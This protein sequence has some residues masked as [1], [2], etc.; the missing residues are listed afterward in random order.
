MFGIFVW[1]YSEHFQFEHLHLA[2]FTYLWTPQDKN[3]DADYVVDG[4][5]HDVDDVDDDDDD[6]YDGDD[7]PGLRE[8]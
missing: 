3:D 5:C 6:D 7:E 2:N 4:D 1:H 8:I